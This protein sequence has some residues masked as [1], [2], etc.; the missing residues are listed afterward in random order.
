M[1]N[2][3]VFMVLISIISMHYSYSM[4]GYTEIK[5]LLSSDEK[6]K[7][8]VNIKKLY[9]LPK[10]YSKK[11]SK[12]IE[13]IITHYYTSKVNNNEQ[14]FD[15]SIFFTKNAKVLSQIIGG[16]VDTWKQE[17]KPVVFIATLYKKLLSNQD[18]YWAGILINTENVS[19]L[20]DFNK[21]EIYKIDNKILRSLVFHKYHN[22]INEHERYNYR[23][24]FYALCCC[25]AWPLDMIFSCSRCI[26]E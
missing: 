7:K 18:S 14:Q 19:D 23:S 22:L 10:T 1:K 6:E 21:S 16:T 8:K 2:M 15:S 17:T 12:K 26:N 25:I 3:P 20:Q 9:K 24:A 4:E 13:A 5:N 11:A